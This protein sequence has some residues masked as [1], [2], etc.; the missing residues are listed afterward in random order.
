MASGKA[1][2]AAKAAGAIVAGGGPEDPAGD[3]KAAEIVAKGAAAKGG[4]GKKGGAAKGGGAGGGSS[5]GPT[6]EQ[7]AQNREKRAAESHAA[8]Q[9]RLA[10]PSTG[11]K[12]VGWAFSANRR[13]L[14]AEYVLCM[15]IVILGTL[16]APADSQ[17][18][19][20]RAL[21]KGSALSGLFMI[22]ALLAA[23]GPGATRTA[24]AL[25]TL[26]TASYALTSSDVHNVVTW[27]AKFFAAPKKSTTEDG[28]K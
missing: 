8:R 2:T 15:A 21:V 23:G 22:L 28:S 11:K 7:R 5:S 6:S 19:A 1:A 4:A 17:D 20:M 12:A 25:G 10:K 27:T 14:V 3:A 9:S 24:T 13:V 18:T 26:V 16:M